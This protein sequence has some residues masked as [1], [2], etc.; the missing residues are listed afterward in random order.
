MRSQKITRA[1]DSIQPDPETYDRL[2]AEVLARADEAPVPSRR[3]GRRVLLIAAC[4]ALV[5]AISVAGQAAYQKWSLPQPETYQ[6]TEMGNIDI[7]SQTQYSHETIV[8]PETAKPLTDEAFISRAVEIL[9]SV[10]LEDV[11][12]SQ[13]T[14]SRQ[15]ELYWD[16]EEAE[17]SFTEDSL[18][19]SVTFDA[20][21]GILLKLS[22]IDWDEAAESA[23]ETQEEAEALARK[24]YAILPVAQGYELTGVTEYDEQY[25]SYEFC[26]K[27]MEG[28]YNYYEMVRLGINPKTG[29]LC[30]CNVFYVPLL[31]DHEPGD[32]PLTQEEAEEIAHSCKHVTLDRYTLKKAEVAVVFPNWFFSDKM[33]ETIDVRAS[34]V[35][36]L[37]WSLVYED[38]NSE[39]ADEIWIYVDYYTG[40]ILGGDMTV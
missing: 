29:R 32:V 34:K 13:M 23:C 3:I 6:P 17:V 12:T 1:Y 14:V 38:T 16:R 28:L 26:Q 15:S 39:F 21:T 20:D 35:T 7:H 10:G 36:R 18:Q 31:D 5:A 33:P 2:L 40:E 25:W 30:G 22:G 37:G 24:Y 19:T 11:D 27:V 4:V 8:E 9:Q